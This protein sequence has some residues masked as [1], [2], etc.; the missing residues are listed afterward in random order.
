[1]H[2]RRRR[3]GRRSRRRRWLR[4]GWGWRRRP[5]WLRG[6]AIRSQGRRCGPHPRWRRGPPIGARYAPRQ[7]WRPDPWRRWRGAELK[8]QPGSVLWIAEGDRP[9]V[10]DEHR[11]HPHSVD[12]DA[13]FTA[14]DGYPLPAVVMQH[15]MDGRRRGSRAVDAD[16]GSA[17]AA[18]RHVPADGKGVS[19]GSEPDDHGGSECS[20]R[21]N[22]PFRP[23][24]HP[25]LLGRA[26]V[27]YPPSCADKRRRD[28]GAGDAAPLPGTSE[29]RPVAEPARHPPGRGAV[30]SRLELTSGGRR[31]PAWQVAARSP[32]PGRPAPG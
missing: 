25:S 6:P 14:V 4:P 8:Y 16:I 17:V 19:V 29:M 30:G 32:Q 20:R 1:V 9:A 24:P 31:A 2:R 7:W 27:V 15:H 18:D 12:V 22:I 5:P 26:T 3:H 10:M 13:A 21:H 11:R 23:F 28:V